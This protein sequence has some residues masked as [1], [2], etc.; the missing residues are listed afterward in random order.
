M[1]GAVL[2]DLRA[3]LASSGFSLSLLMEAERF[4]PGMLRAP[5]LPVL[6][7]WLGRRPEPGAALA[8]LFACDDTLSGADARDALGAALLGALVE[9]GI[10]ATGAD[11]GVTAR[12]QLRP[13][14]DDLWFLSDF[15]ALGADAVMGPSTGTRFLARLIPRAFTGTALDVG[16][17]AGSLAL[18]AARRRAR[19]AVGVDVNPR[20]I[21]LARFNA[22]LND[23]AADFEVGDGVGP[24]AGE[25]FDLVLAQPPYVV[26]PPDARDA[27]YLHGGAQGDELAL[28][29]V[30]A[31]PGVLAAGGRGLVLME[32]PVRAGEPLARQLRAAMGDADASVLVLT[33]KAPSPAIQAS[34][35]AALADPLFG[36]HYA[37]EV[38]RYLDHF[39]SL[40]IHEVCGALAVLSSP[41]ATDVAAG[42]TTRY[43]LGLALSHAAYDAASLDRFA[44]GLALA[45]RPPEVLERQPLRAAPTARLV[46]EAPLAGAGT[47]PT[48]GTLVHV[49]AP[50]IGADWQLGE[51]EVEILAALCAAETTGAAAR[52]LAE[53]SVATPDQVLA[54]ARSALV[55]G[56]LTIDAG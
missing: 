18:A 29:F 36:P 12:F 16:C 53:R 32:S 28:A 9:A 17:G 40:G 52:A 47:A 11:G 30:A 43:T 54:L 23:L 55:H 21:A 15:L 2:G 6:R 3:R 10:L 14:E 26:R 39:E 46:R 35:Y 20:A 49:E 41:A 7:W 48:G 37:D 1:T 22:R 33:G 34:T 45:G 24:V 44:A 42:T 25:R 27:T 5:R 8:R 19:R 4:A 50:D 31:I 56:A 38:R 51:A 13:I